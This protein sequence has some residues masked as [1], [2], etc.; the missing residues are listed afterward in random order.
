MHFFNNL[1]E[2]RINTGFFVKVYIFFYAKNGYQKDDRMNFL[3]FHG[4]QKDNRELQKDNRG[5]QKGDR[6]L[7]KGDRELQK[8]D[9]GSSRF[10]RIK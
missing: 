2:T 10:D 8:G 3:F 7:Q 1:L 9:R 6:E 5:C 4:C